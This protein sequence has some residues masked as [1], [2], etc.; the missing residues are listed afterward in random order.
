[1][2][3]RGRRLLTP[4]PRVEPAP[5]PWS[6]QRLA[7]VLGVLGLAAALMV[8][9]LGL[10]VYYSFTG[11]GH[12]HNANGTGS[13][14]TPSASSPTTEK[15][16]TLRPSASPSTS[17]GLSAAEKAARDALA[18]KLM[19]KTTLDDAQPGEPISARDPG[20]I[21][22]PKGTRRDA[23]GVPTGFPHTPQGAIAAMASIDETAFD[24][25]TMAGVRNVIRV[26]AAPGG[27]TT[28][29]WSGI[30]AMASFF[31]GAGLSGA[32]TQQLSLVMTPVMGLIKGTV[33]PDFVVTCVDFEL[34]ATLSRTQRVAT[35]DCERMVWTG[36]KWMIGAGTEPAEPP[37]VWPGTD[38][39]IKVGYMDLVS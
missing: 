16:L 38:L 36:G 32:R 37:S 9:G 20:Q 14:A 18:M 12:Q 29:S 10:G 35:A 8:F 17:G 31:D 4:A 24:S 13:T 25:G 39:A 6:R 34:D 2:F 5:P 21:R 23:L 19:P 33:G 26:W 28:T 3:K 22:V 30:K 1:M 7:L 11:H 27:P 15:Y